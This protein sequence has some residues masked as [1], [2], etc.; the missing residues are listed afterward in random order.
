MRYEY[1]LESIITD[2]PITTELK[3]EIDKIIFSDMDIKDKRIKIR[4]L[5]RKGLSTI[6]IKM[7]IKL[8]DYIQGV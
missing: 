2:L 7:F 4:K 1:D 3:D 6:F 8:F 5:K